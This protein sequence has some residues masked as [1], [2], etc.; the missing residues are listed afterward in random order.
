M[1]L[2]KVTVNRMTIVIMTVG[3]KFGKKLFVQND[4]RQNGP[5]AVNKMTENF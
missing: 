4:F 2:E 1:T 3:N 5:I